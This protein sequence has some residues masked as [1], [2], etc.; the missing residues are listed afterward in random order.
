M[1]K[2]NPLVSNFRGLDKLQEAMDELQL[3]VNDNGIRHTLGAET[4]ELTIDDQSIPQLG[5]SIGLPVD[6]QRKLDA[7]N[8]AGIEAD[9]VDLVL[10]AEDP[11]LKERA[12]IFSGPFDD[13][14]FEEEIYRRGARRVKAL[15]NTREGIRIYASLILNSSIAPLAGRPHRQGTKLATLDFRIK[16][17]PVSGVIDPRPLSDEIIKRFGLSRKT[18]LFVDITGDLTGTESV[19]DTVTVYVDPK[20]L[21]ALMTRRSGIEYEFVATNLAIVAMQQIAYC[22][23]NEL[24]Q[25]KSFVW[26]DDERPILA[27][28][29]DRL[30][31]VA[32]V[33]ESKLTKDSTVEMLRDSP[34]VAAS[35]LTGL[36]N[37][38]RD[39][40]NLVF[41]A[42]IQEDDIT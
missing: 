40:R 12:C 32:R 18:Q 16:G 29:R 20:L 3:I 11:F 39:A 34:N 9:K 37:F 17:Y 28:M 7:V 21:S 8:G 26:D 24:A 6:R 19:P 38:N 14:P 23:S 13:V 10:V 31:E 30:N 27:L 33:G 4:N 5:I 42:S 25:D 41:G 35:L 22:L 36:S 15:E 1:S 2:E